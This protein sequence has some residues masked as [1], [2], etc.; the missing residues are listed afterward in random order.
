MSTLPFLGGDFRQSGLHQA[1]YA[2]IDG[3]KS[4]HV[5]KYFQIQDCFWGERLI[6]SGI[7]GKGKGTLS[8][9][10]NLGDIWALQWEDLGTRLRLKIISFNINING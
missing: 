2:A 6:L 9:D 1:I 7:Q 5:V 4:E 3:W 8:L 10:R